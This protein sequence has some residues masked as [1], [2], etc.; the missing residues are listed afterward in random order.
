MSHEQIP[1]D[2]V[3]CK[4]IVALTEERLSLASVLMHQEGGTINPE[5]ELVEGS[6]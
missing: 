1:G 6:A 5:S 3:L 2:E 4:W